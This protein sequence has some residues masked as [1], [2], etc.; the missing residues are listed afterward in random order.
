M[1]FSW[2]AFSA[3]LPWFTWENHLPPRGS[4]PIR[5]T[6]SLDVERAWQGLPRSMPPV[7]GPGPTGLLRQAWRPVAQD[8]LPQVGISLLGQPITAP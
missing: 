6:Q 4:G 2:L 8:P 7:A 5:K 1:L 3:G